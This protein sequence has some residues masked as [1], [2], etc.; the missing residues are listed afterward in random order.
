MTDLMIDLETLGTKPGCVILA[1]GAVQFDLAT[2]Y[3]GNQFLSKIDLCDSVSQGFHVEQATSDWWSKQPVNTAAHSFCGT[4]KLSDSLNSFSNFIKRTFP[5]PVKVW[6][7][8]SRFDLGILEYAYLKLSLQVPWSSFNEWDYRTYS[9]A[10]AGIRESVEFVGVKHEPINDC[11]HQIKVVSAVKK[12]ISTYES[13]L[14]SD[15]GLNGN[16]HLT[17]AA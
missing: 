8:S 12:V 15:N 1:I 16:H 11:I 3:T 5:E 7:N 13:V 10:I 14:R 2:G 9:K 17:Q 4:I 6:G